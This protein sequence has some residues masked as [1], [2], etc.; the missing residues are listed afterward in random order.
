MSN[1]KPTIGIWANESDDFKRGLKAK[2]DAW[3]D[4]IQDGTLL[5]MT[6]E[7]KWYKITDV[8]EQVKAE[9]ARLLEEE[10]Q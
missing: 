3:K 9:R 2:D 7:N 10:G 6:Q 1:M 4:K 8:T 5:F